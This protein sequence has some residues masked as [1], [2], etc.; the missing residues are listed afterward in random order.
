M[1]KSR[2]WLSKPFLQALEPFSALLP[3]LLFQE[4]VSRLTYGCSCSSNLLIASKVLVSG[5]LILG[6][7]A[8]IGMTINSIIAVGRVCY[9][10]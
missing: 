4:A 6:G 2:G 5:T 9:L 3:P 1:K 7:V 8:L 10:S